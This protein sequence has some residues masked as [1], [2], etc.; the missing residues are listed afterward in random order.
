MIIGIDVSKLKLDVWSMVNPQD[1]KQ[2]HFIVSNNEKG[3]KQIIKT[4]KKQKH[5]MED[6]LFCFENTGIYSMPLS[7]CLSKFGADYW[8]VPALEIKRSKGISRGKNDKNDAKEIAFYAFT[9][10]YKL[11]LNA[12]PEKEIAQLKVLF[13]EREKLVKAIKLMDTTKELKGFMPDEIINDTLK[14]NAKTVALLKQQLKKL[15]EKIQEIIEQNQKIKE[16]YKLAS[17]VPGIGKQT[18]IYLIITTN[19]FESFENWRKLACYAGVAPFEYT[20]GTSIKGR[21]KVNN[22]ADKKMKSMLQMCVLTAI[23][24]DAELKSYYNRK[25]EEGKNPMLIM[26]N[27]RCKLIAR[28]FSVVKRGTPFVNIHK[29]AA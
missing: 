17:S 14:L 18:A 29:F 26:N 28:V 22:L 25:K 2:E 20:S 16:Q 4:I 5:S 11:K 15:E 23:K 13:S 1:S 9:H 27:I 12:L 7:Y 19:C 10:L 3:I 21:T 8:V 24:N 6:C